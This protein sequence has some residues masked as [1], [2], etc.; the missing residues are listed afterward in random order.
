MLLSQLTTVL[1]LLS[2]ACL[3]TGL[4]RPGPQGSTPP[5]WAATNQTRPLGRGAQASPGPSSALSSW[6][7]F[8]DLQKTRRMGSGGL[9]REREEASTMTLPLDPQEVAQE[10][11]KAVPFTQVLTQPGCTPL[12]LRNRLCMGHCSSLYVPGADPAPF[13]LCNSCAPARGHWVPL[14]LWCRAGSPASRRRVKTYTVL[15]ERCQCSP[16]A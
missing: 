14:F 3:P 2:G 16:K 1:S 11:C 15:V 4:G 7:A 9:Q 8:L 12:R 13:V 6:K 5:P 10:R